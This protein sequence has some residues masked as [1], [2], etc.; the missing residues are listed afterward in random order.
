MYGVRVAWIVSTALALGPAPGAA[1]PLYEG[2]ETTY[3]SPVARLDARTVPRPPS[4]AAEPGENVGGSVLGFDDFLRQPAALGL[5]HA[6]PYRHDALALVGLLRA[7]PRPGSMDAVKT[8][9]ADLPRAS[10]SEQPDRVAELDDPELGRVWVRTDR[11]LSVIEG[12][13]HRGSVLGSEM[14]V[15]YPHPSRVLSRMEQIAIEKDPPAWARPF[16]ARSSSHGR[17]AR[18]ARAPEGLWANVSDRLYAAADGALFGR[19][20]P[21]AALLR[22][23]E[24]PLHPEDPS[25]GTVV[26]EA[27][28]DPTP[29]ERAD[30]VR[31]ASDVMRRKPEELDLASVSLRRQYWVHVTMPTEKGH[32]LL[33]SRG[34]TESHQTYGF[35]WRQVFNPDNTA[36]EMKTQLEFARGVRDH[37]RPPSSAALDGPPP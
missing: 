20:K 12:H 31:H 14:I 4:S 7:L 1:Q 27:L 19:V 17:L 28:V 29:T 35:L 25:A 18:R 33:V 15:E 37:E 11:T 21:A 22:R 10:G 16:V 9:L 8:L 2:L 34:Y 30:L 6:G 26:I 5:A 3:R 13:G 36:A 32:T 24:F 23:F